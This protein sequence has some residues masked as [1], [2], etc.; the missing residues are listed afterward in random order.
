MPITEARLGD[1]TIFDRLQSSAYLN[2]CGISPLCKPVREALQQAHLAFA[3]LGSVALAAQL[4]SEAELR[5]GLG[6]LLGA[7]AEHFSLLPNVTTAAIAVANCFPW[8]RGDRVVLVRGEFPANVVPWLQAAETFGLEPRWLEPGPGLLEGL[9]DELGSGARLVALSAVAFQTGWRAPLGEVAELCRQ[10]GARLFVDAIQALGVVP[11]EVHGIDYL[12]GGSHKWMLGPLG[13]GFLYLS[14]E[15]AREL[16]PRLAGW[17]SL[18]E[19]LD[20]LFGQPLRY[21]RPVRHQPDFLEWGSRN[22]GG[23]AGLNASVRLLLDLGVANIFEHVQDYL[24]RLEAGCLELG[25][26]SLRAARATERSGILALRPP[27]SLSAPTLIERLKA[28]RVV[29][30]CPEGVLRFGP[31]FANSVAEIPVILEVLQ[32][33]VS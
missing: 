23:Y 19:P 24:D 22:H 18:E 21:D 9:A 33:A 6:R 32:R 17:L 8:Q 1:R 20:F 15:R 10:H 27:G 13:C 16:K 11:L 29:A 31:H 14:P 25:F 12:A 5:A 3:E 2:H 7:P 30:T 26:T 28:E 4:E